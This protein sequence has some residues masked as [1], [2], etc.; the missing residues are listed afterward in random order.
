MDNKYYKDIIHKL[1]NLKNSG[2]FSRLEIKNGFIDPQIDILL[3]SFANSVQ[4]I[5]NLI[6][7][8]KN[9]IKLN[10]M[11][12]HYPFLLR[13]RIS[14]MIVHPRVNFE[15]NIFK[16]D[17][18][19]KFQI[20]EKE[21]IYTY[22]TCDNNIIIPIHNVIST[23]KYSDD[24]NITNEFGNYFISIK[25]QFI[26]GF[27]IKICKIN[28]IKI[29]FIS[30][31]NELL[32]ELLLSMCKNIKLNVYIQQ[33]STLFKI[34]N[35]EFY[36]I[37]DYD[38][39]NDAP[40]YLQSIINYFN[41][42]LSY[43]IFNLKIDNF[44]V[45]DNQNIE[46]II[47]I[48][49]FI[50]IKDFIKINFLILTN[51]DSVQSNMMIFN[52]TLKL[53]A[54]IDYISRDVIKIFNIKNLY[55]YDKILFKKRSV[56]NFIDYSYDNMYPI[57][58]NIYWQHDKNFFDKIDSDF[59]SLYMPDLNTSQISYMN[60]IMQYY[61]TA[62]IYQV[63]NRKINIDNII[64]ITNNKILIQNIILYPTFSSFLNFKNMNILDNLFNIYNIDIIHTKN[65][66]GVLLN[67][68]NSLSILNG[69]SIKF[70]RII[71]DIRIEYEFSESIINNQYTSN[72]ILYKIKII[73]ED[74]YAIGFDFY[75][76]ISKFI[77]NL[78][79][80]TIN[81]HVIFYNLQETKIIYNEYSNF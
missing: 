69:Y 77:I 21:N 18:F 45:L 53:P 15:K 62:D 44:E 12:L 42:P 75:S 1:I 36:D 50:N 80:M 8:S 65:K 2:F 4:E 6:E 24:L 32:K 14:K 52:N 30:N 81:S 26:N 11:N 13:P 63:I 70:D 67:I 5:D 46:F 38:C 55:S 71:N 16:V 56:Q 66:R 29:L 35:L 7:N 34:G 3:H 51:I 59:I 76:A 68:L 10:L 54:Y 19:S 20:Y 61:Y 64:C 28:I 49:K 31:E 48:T 33:E 27:N 23:T 41:F 57:L 74:E 72:L 22:K 79:G 37:I 78:F 43:N 73:I 9:Q 17:A 39:Q 58:E 47:P 40:K 60:E 25:L